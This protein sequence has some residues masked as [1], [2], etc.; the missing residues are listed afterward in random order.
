[1]PRGF[2]KETGLSLSPTKKGDKRPPRSKEWSE[3]M[4][5]ANK[6]KK[7]TEETRKKMSQ[8]MMGRKPPKTAFQKGMR[9]SPSTEFKK[10]FTPWNKGLKGFNAG[11]KN[12]HWRGGVSY[13]MNQ[14]SQV[15]HHKRRIK[16]KENGGSFSLGEWL[17]LKA[18]Y[19]WT[20]PCC[21]R[22][23]PEIKLTIDHIIPIIKGGSNNIE[24]IQPLCK[25]CNSRKRA[26]I[27]KFNLN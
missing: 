2:S 9:P 22:K 7:R 10:G 24:N 5:L 19:N 25:N 11:E 20:C 18:Q 21:R 23:E 17:N 4:R 16:E 12:G 14:Y 26:K 8:V 6:G 15:A 3:K 1:M 13:N 27:I